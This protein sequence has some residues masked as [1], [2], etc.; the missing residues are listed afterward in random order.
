L[1]R[2][3]DNQDSLA[4]GEVFED[5]IAFAAQQVENEAEQ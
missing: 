4:Q 3:R 2:S 5:E 1:R